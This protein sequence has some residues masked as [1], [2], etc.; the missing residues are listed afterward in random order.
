LLEDLHTALQACLALSCASLL[1]LLD[2]KTWPLSCASLLTLLDEKTALSCVPLLTL[3][4]EKIWP[5][6]LVEA[7]QAFSDHGESDHEPPVCC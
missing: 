2:D 5:L 4:A 7:W 1:T 3:L 6:S